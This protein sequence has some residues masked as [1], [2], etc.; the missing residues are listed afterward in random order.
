MNKI[1]KKKKPVSRAFWSYVKY[2]PANVRARVVRAQFE[3]SS[4]P[5]DIIFKQAETV[6]EIKQALQ[7]VHESYVALNYTDANPTK[8]HF[9]KFIA[10]PTSVILIIKSKSEVI[11]TMSVIPD[12]ALGLPCDTTW[13]LNK[14]RK[15]GN[16]IGEISSLAIKKSSGLHRGKL[17]LPLCK[18]MLLFCM[19]TLRLDGLVMAATLEVEPFYTDVLLFEKVVEKTGQRH[20]LVKGN[21]STCCYLP[22]NEKTAL[23]YKA[24]YGKFDKPRNIHKFFFEDQTENIIFPDP[25]NCIQAYLIQKNIAQA[26]VIRE[27]QS[28]IASFTDVEK[29]IISDLDI[30]HILPIHFEQKMLFKKKGPRPEIRFRGWCFFAGETSPTA[31]QFVNISQNGFS[32]NV[33]DSDRKIIIGDKLALVLHYEGKLIQCLAQ[34]RWIQWEYRLG[35]VVTETSAQWTQFVEKILDSLPDVKSRETKNHKTG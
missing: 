31:F 1:K 33:K 21:P 14:Y 27:N 15:G 25:Q 28:L 32:L 3:I 8:L 17:L 18:M 5:R 26:H 10:L 7:L 6:D 24:V 30:S 9:S 34:V 19:D 35:C 29:Q 13:N 16:L 12:S 22:L 20:D 4:L 23:K 2:L 11:G